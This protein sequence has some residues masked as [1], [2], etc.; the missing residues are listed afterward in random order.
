MLFMGR[1]FAAQSYAKW[2]LG[3]TKMLHRKKKKDLKTAKIMEGIIKY[4]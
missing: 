3:K 2:L 1:R 4:S